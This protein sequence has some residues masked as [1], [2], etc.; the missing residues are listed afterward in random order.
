MFFKFKESYFYNLMCFDYLFINRKYLL[1]NHPKIL[2]EF[3]F[4]EFKIQI[5][6]FHVL[7]RKYIGKLIKN[8]K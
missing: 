7:R 4:L 6:L 2:K 5:L 8:N 1:K 3:I